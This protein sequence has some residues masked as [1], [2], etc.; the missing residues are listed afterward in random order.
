MCL[1][2]IELMEQTGA[3][4]QA[5]CLPGDFLRNSAIDRSKEGNCVMKL[6]DVDAGIWFGSFFLR[7][8]GCSL[9]L[10]TTGQAEFD[11]FYPFC[12][13]AIMK[14]YLHVASRY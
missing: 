1:G 8:F 10:V 9:H 14:G 7:Q 2:E 13:V 6:F 11:P 5:D 4:H 12:L 3:G